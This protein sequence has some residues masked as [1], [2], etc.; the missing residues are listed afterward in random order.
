[1]SECRTVWRHEHLGKCRTC[2]HYTIRV[3][4]EAYET[5]IHDDGSICPLRV[6]ATAARFPPEKVLAF[7]LDSRGWQEYENR[8]KDVKKKRGRSRRKR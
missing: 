5:V 2:G 3:L 7:L 4:T 1:M 6:E 8:G